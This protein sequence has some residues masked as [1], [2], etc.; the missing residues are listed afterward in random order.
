MILSAHS[1]IRYLILLAGVGVVVFA[2]H[3]MV[4]RRPYDERMRKLAALFAGL[5]HLQI[6]IGMAT[7][8]TGQFYPALAGHVMMMVF[9]AVTAQIVPSVMRRRPLEERS[10]APFLVG[11][12]AAMGL[13]YGGVR[14]IGQSL[15]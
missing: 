14:A 6:L 12:I 11:T 10:W 3:G 8:F 9:A 5:I 15:L 13:L 4:T 1:G 2:L 7:I